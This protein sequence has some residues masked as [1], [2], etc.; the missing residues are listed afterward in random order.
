MAEPLLSGIY[1][2]NADELSLLATFPRLRDIER[3]HGGL[4]RGALAQRKQARAAQPSARR[5]T[6]FVSLDDGMGVLVDALVDALDDCDLRSGVR[7]TALELAAGSYSLSLS[8]GARLA[9]DA[10]VLATPAYVSAE[11]MRGP[12]PELAELLDG[13]QYV[14]TATISLS[15]EATAVARQ[16]VGR[17]FVIPRAEGRALTAVT[18]TSQKF[19]GRAP[20]GQAL[21]RGFVGRAGSE[22]HAA[23]PDDELVAL[24]RREL[25]DILGI[26]AEPL[27][28]RVF[29]WPCAMPQYRVGHLERLAHIDARV[30]RLPGLALAGNA[31]RAVGIPDL[32]ADSRGR[33]GALAAQLR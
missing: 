7:V 1:A 8:D 18:W 13:I 2:G 19:S 31:Y 16:A 30:A 6:P 33:A 15:Y 21:L 25:R 9:A 3:Q 29:R 26:A 11:L 20:E 28:A 27:A 22:Q 10:V 14:S 32:I 4:L 5:Q 17:G 12:A 23:L 24:T